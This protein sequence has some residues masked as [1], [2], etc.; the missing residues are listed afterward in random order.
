MSLVWSPCSACGADG[1]Y[2]DF[3]RLGAF[4]PG[5]MSPIPPYRHELEADIDPFPVACC[6]AFFFL[7]LDDAGPECVISKTRASCWVRLLRWWR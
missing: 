2:S 5:F 4:I 7:L 6:S 1:I 3:L